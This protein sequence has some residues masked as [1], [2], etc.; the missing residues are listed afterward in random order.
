MV[1][2]DAELVQRPIFVRYLICLGVGCLALF[3]PQGAHQGLLVAILVG[4]MPI[5]IGLMRINKPN[6]QEVAFVLHDIVLAITAT[7][8]QPSLWPASVIARTMSCSALSS[9]PRAPS[10]A[11]GLPPQWRWVSR[12]ISGMLTLGRSSC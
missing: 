3:V 12:V 2:P 1:D 11:L 7:L 9:A 4:S 10:P 8:I 5:Q 6:R